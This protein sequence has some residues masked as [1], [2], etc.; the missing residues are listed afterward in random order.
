MYFRTTGDS[1]FRIE[2]LKD[3]KDFM[4]GVAMAGN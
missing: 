4:D 1:R 3:I 2:A